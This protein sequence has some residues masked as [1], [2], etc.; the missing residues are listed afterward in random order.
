MDSGEVASV[1]DANAGANIIRAILAVAAVCARRFP[2]SLN[3]GAHRAPLQPGR[4]MIGT[5]LGSYEIL[6]S[7]GAGL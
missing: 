1:R 3:F 5:T 7:V 6:S 2:D 4:A